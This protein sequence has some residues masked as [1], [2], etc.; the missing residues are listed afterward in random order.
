MKRFWTRLLGLAACLSG[1]GLAASGCT[2]LYATTTSGSTAQLSFVNTVAQTIQPV[3]QAAASVTA[4]NGLAL[5]PVTGDL[6]WINRTG[7]S[8]ILNVYD[9]QT[10]TN[11]VVGS[12]ALPAEG[13]VNI[14]ATF[15]NSTGTPRLFLLYSNYQ[16]HEVNLATSTYRTL[17]I[18]LPGG[19]SKRT[20]TSGDIIFVG[21]TLYAVMDA[22][23]SETS[24]VY[25]FTLGAPTATATTL[26]ASD[27]VRLRTSSGF[28]T[29]NT[30][31]GIAIN[32]ADNTTYVSHSDGGNFVG[33][34]TTGTGT[35]VNFPSTTNAPSDLSDC[36]NVPA[37][38]TISKT[39]SS[40]SVIQG[41]DT[42][43]TLTI[44][45]SNPSPFFL[46]SALTDTL[47]AGVVVASSPAATTTCTQASSSAA[48]TITAV[49]G[50]GSFSLPANTRI[51]A[52]GC[53]VRVN[54]TTTSTG[55]K[56]N[57]LPVGS[58]DTTAGSNTAE[59]RATLTVNAHVTGTLQKTQRNVTQGGTAGTADV[60]GRPGDVIEYCLTATHPGT[61]VADATVANLKDTLA[62][63]LT[64]IPGAYGGKD[65]QL[66]KGTTVTTLTF[67]AGD[68][69]AA[70][71]GRTLT[72]DILP[73][74]SRNPTARVCFQ[75]RVS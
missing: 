60:G 59:A 51:P 7:T 22:N 65:V 40:G 1:G 70:L 62:S 18:N 73:W 6:Y 33:R 43:V 13:A 2:S 50:T 17:T 61:G 48:Q 69:A 30:V 34:L 74:G 49:A 3:Y 72:V 47:P 4:I 8:N 12:L 31:N 54:V 36:N 27:P 19:Y 9:T 45:N 56:V 71:S 21:T 28:I 16:A 35:V 38:P 41:E 57:S 63:T 53:T 5:N 67:A 32:G 42:T 25:Y 39:F 68:D 55:S 23:T 44:G 29:V 10:Q 52:G 64:P 37:V 14:G 46:E 11:T 66:T 20:S 58:V 26:T 75:A 15:D 24:G